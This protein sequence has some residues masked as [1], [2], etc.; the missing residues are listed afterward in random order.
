MNDDLICF[1]SEEATHRLVLLHGWGADAED[2]IPVGKELSRIVGVS[3]ELVS[4]RAPQIHP[5]GIGRQW[6]GLF[7]ADWAAVPLVVTNLQSRLRALSN[8]SIP[9]NRTALL[10]F[11]QGG[12]M[13]VASGCELPLAGLIGCSAYPHPNWS[14]SRGGPPILLTHGTKDEVVPF[15]ASKEL[16][17]SLQENQLD[18]ELLAFEGGHEI[19]PA[20]LPQIRLALNQWF[21]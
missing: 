1:S 8:M 11:S 14:P 7:P 20:V 15:A 18:A 13:A 2:L 19:P 9:L 3:I 4:L 12:A 17:G 5:Q 16:L 21:S 10:G 6:Y